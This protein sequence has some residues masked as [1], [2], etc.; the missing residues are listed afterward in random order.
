ME[1]TIQTIQKPD[2]INKDYNEYLKW[3]EDKKKK[4]VQNE[5]NKFND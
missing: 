4:E 3:K 5:A 2:F 1:T